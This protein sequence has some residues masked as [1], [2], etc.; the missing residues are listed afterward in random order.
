M[1]IRINN[2]DYISKPVVLELLN[3]LD[4]GENSNFV[5]SVPVG[6]D[7]YYGDVVSVVGSSVQ[8][9]DGK[10]DFRMPFENSSYGVPILVSMDN[11]DY[12]VKPFDMMYFKKLSTYE[13]YTD[14]K[15]FFNGFLLRA[16]SED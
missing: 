4:N 7:A 3:D 2:I 10:I 6:Y 5:H 12:Q 1:N 11:Q 14:Q 13:A 16:K 8:Q 9:Y 15:F